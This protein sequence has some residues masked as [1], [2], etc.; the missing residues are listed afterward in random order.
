M[1]YPTVDAPYGL[2]PINLIGGQPYAGSTRQITI[3]SGY[4]TNIF[5]GD[6]VKRVADG[7]LEKDTGPSTTATTLTLPMRI[8]DVVEETADS[9]GNFTEVIVKWNAPYEDSNIAKGGH[10]YMVATGL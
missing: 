8:I 10:A 4:A 5:C 9:D 3:A 2:K 6:V 1:A 7:P